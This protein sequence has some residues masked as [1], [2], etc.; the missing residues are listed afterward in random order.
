MFQVGY[1]NLSS[2]G[3]APLRAKSSINCA[4][5]LR[6]RQAASIALSGRIAL[7]DLK[8][9]RRR[10]KNT[11]IGASRCDTRTILD[12][13]QS[14]CTKFPLM[15]PLIHSHLDFPLHHPPTR[16]STHMH[17]QVQTLQTA[18]LAKFILV[19]LFSTIR[20]CLSLRV[21]VKYSGESVHRSQSSAFVR[22]PPPRLSGS[23]VD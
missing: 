21:A 4:A 6:V 18:T 1:K 23:Q 19:S 3:I 16:T 7:H 22:A 9:R 2:T 10:K 15:K 20:V 17:T 13:L 11:A 12:C 5:I 14:L 8:R